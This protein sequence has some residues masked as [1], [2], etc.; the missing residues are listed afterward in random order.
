MSEQKPMRAAVTCELQ[1]I[2]QREA[3]A[4]IVRHHRHHPPPRGYKF[5]IAVNDG[6]HVVGVITVGRP[7]ARERRWVHR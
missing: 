1:P 7:V 4:F 6:A 3:N 2:T 5:A